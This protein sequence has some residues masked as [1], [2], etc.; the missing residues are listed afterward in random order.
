MGYS[1]IDVERALELVAATPKNGL[2]I[3][4][5]RDAQSYAAGHIEGA[6]H[7]DN[8]TLQEFLQAADPGKPLLVY[9]YHGNMSQGAAAYFAEQGFAETYSLDGGFEH[10]QPPATW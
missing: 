4:D 9:C 10:W 1:R 6:L 8:S 5:V 2:Q 3:I 7:L